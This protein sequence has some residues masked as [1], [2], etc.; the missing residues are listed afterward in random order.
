MFYLLPS[1]LSSGFLPSPL[2][3]GFDVS[4]LVCL[5]IAFHLLPSVYSN[6]FTVASSLCS[7][8]TCSN[9]LNLLSL[10]NSAIGCAC[11]QVSTC[12]IVFPLAHRNIR[13]SVVF[14]I[15]ANWYSTFYLISPL[16]LP[17]K[18]GIHELG[19]RR[20]FVIPLSLPWTYVRNV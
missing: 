7:L 17:G 2:S 3:L 6:I 16:F 18:L 12:I 9:H 13:I 4:A 14:M 5:A 1:Q 15:D 11:F 8:G 20:L 19:F 10:R